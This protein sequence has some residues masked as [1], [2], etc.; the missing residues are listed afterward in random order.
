MKVETS[1]DSILIESDLPVPP[2]RAWTLLTERRHR[3]V[4][5]GDHVELDV[6]V[7]G[8]LRESWSDAGRPVITSGTVTR[9]EPGVGLEMTWRDDDWPGDTHVVLRLSERASGS[10]VVLE[11]TGW[12]VHPVSTRKRLTEAHAVG[13]SQYLEALADYASHVGP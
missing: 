9:C 5:W 3:V 10:R 13:W 11:H 7:G 2:E 8:R 1:A 12:T 6:K 4:W